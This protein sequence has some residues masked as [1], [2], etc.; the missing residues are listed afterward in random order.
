[1]NYKTIMTDEDKELLL[2]SNTVIYTKLIIKEQDT[3]PEIVLTENDSVK[4]WDYADDRYVP[5]VGFIGQFVA[6]TLSGELQN[7]NDEFNIEDREVQ[8][9]FGIKDF[10]KSDDEISWYTLGSFF[11]QKPEDN[12]V[13]DNTKFEAMDY[14]IKFNKDFDANYTSSDFPV[15][16]NDAVESKQYFNAK[17]LAQYV[18]GQVGV[19]FGNEH[20]INDD[21]IITTNQ[22]VSGDSCRDVMRYVSQLA[23]GWVRIGWDD[24]CYID[25]LETNLDNIPS[26][27]EIDNDHYYSLKTQK[28]VYGPVDRI[29]IGMENIDGEALFIPRDITDYNTT[30]YV[31]D[32]PMTF[33]NDLRNEIIDGGEYLLGLAYTPFESE[34]PGHPWLLGKDLIKI[35]DMEGNGK[36]TYAFNVNI[37]YKGHIKTKLEAPAFTKTE[38]TMAYAADLYKTLKNVK[39]TVDKQDGVITLLNETVKASAD[40]L[41][42]LKQSVEQTITDTYSRTQVNDIV[43]G[44]GV[45]GVV[46]ES[47]KSTAGTFD[48]DGLTIE[49]SGSLTKTNLNSDGMII[50]NATGSVDTAMLTVD[51]TGVIADNI[52]VSTYTTLGSHSRFEDYRHTDGTEG[53]GVF[54]VGR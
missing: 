45:D 15:S 14:T 8:V 32:N 18:C 3:L 21:F 34:T 36:Y 29:V 25:E 41:E 5:D 40:G 4:T 38:E 22:F 23:F 16:F 31:Y 30:L 49:Q 20:F 47:V 53:T 26:Y 11:I 24:K 54:W 52:R 42:A 50:Y 6:R 9:C 48:K 2:N 13:S 33:T 43:S 39:V 37:S 10:S 27:N 51:H 35:I 1:M 44:I 46:V 7:I 19:E 28:K 17:Q 12:E